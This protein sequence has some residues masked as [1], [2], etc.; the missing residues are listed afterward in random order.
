MCVFVNDCKCMDGC[1]RVMNEQTVGPV[2][3]YIY[4]DLLGSERPPS[5][6][7]VNELRF[8][9]SINGGHPWSHPFQWDFPFT[10]TIQRAWGSPMTSWK[11]PCLPRHQ[12]PELASAR[13]SGSR[14][15][16]PSTAV[17]WTS[18]AQLIH[19]ARPLA[20]DHRLATQR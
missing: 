8:T 9:V 18:N 4:Y 2:G 1:M 5:V 6:E 13:S 12:I 11:P 10:K 3:I 19:M 7:I 14:A 17:S 20:K 16:R 15:V